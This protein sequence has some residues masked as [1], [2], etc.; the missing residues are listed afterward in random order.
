MVEILW[1]ENGRGINLPT[2]IAY[3]IIIPTNHAAKCSVSHLPTWET[4]SLDLSKL[5]KNPIKKG[6]ISPQLF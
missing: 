2:Y 1:V 3:I 4:S 5:A 6:L